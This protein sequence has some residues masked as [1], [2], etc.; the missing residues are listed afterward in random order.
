MKCIKQN[1]TCKGYNKC[2]LYHSVHKLYLN[3]YKLRSFLK[4]I[5]IIYEVVITFELKFGEPKHIVASPCH[6]HPVLQ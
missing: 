1:I 4:L 6:L 5:C 2:R 3:M